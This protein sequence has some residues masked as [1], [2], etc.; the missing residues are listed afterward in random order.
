MLKYVQS[1]NGP[2]IS[3]IHVFSLTYFYNIPIPYIAIIFFPGKTLNA[4]TK[5]LFH[6]GH[7]FCERKHI[8]NPNYLDTCNV[9]FCSWF[10]N[11]CTNVCGGITLS[12]ESKQY[13]CV[14]CTDVINIHQLNLELIERH[15]ICLDNIDRL[16][17][18]SVLAI[19][20]LH[21][22]CAVSE[23]PWDVCSIHWEIAA[24]YLWISACLLVQSCS[25]PWTCGFGLGSAE[26][27]ASNPPHECHDLTPLL[28]SAT[29]A[30]D[31]TIQQK[32]QQDTV[33][34]LHWTEP[35]EARPNVG[36]TT[37]RRAQ[38]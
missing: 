37:I 16:D 29:V 38:A 24:F 25:C 19:Y 31:P 2:Q 33:P 11:N 9:R 17:N 6:C 15:Q 36:I 1:N 32:W 23:R 3:I 20:S 27:R 12:L 18:N 4:L 30:P 21:L 14:H 28:T 13:L 34:Q 22:F 35:E 10:V 8:I 26:A 7:R 5:N